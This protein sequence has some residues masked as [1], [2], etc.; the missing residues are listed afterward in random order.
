M[1]AKFI[2]LLLLLLS[3]NSIAQ[4]KEEKLFGRRLSGTDS[5]LVLVENR[6]VL[7]Y[8]NDS[9]IFWMLDNKKQNQKAFKKIGMDGDG[10]TYLNFYGLTYD[11]ILYFLKSPKNL[12]KQ[13]EPTL[14]QQE[15]GVKDI[16]TTMD[17]DDF[18]GRR[19]EMK[20]IK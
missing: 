13:Q 1:T 19:W 5:N 15:S 20:K 11:G 8:E 3:L 14:V 6:G 10:N 9:T 16:I 2:F 4:K 17:R 18:G 12:N 7:F